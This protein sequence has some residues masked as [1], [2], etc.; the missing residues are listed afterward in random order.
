MES[1]QGGA[2]SPRADDRKI[3]DE[4]TK[5]EKL[6]VAKSHNDDVVERFAA[7]RVEMSDVLA[8]HLIALGHPED[9]APLRA[10]LVFD[11]V[12]QFSHGEAIDEPGAD[13]EVIRIVTGALDPAI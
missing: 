3:S 2:R 10:R 6:S 4:D 1:I 13:A 11:L 8:A 12:D 9:R 7:F 5:I